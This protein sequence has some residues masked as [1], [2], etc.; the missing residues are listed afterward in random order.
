MTWKYRCKVFETLN[1]FTFWH[2]CLM[3]SWLF[4][5]IEVKRW[6]LIMEFTCLFIGR[7]GAVLALGTAD[8]AA[9]RPPAVQGAE[10]LL[11]QLTGSSWGGTLIRAVGTIEGQVVWSAARHLACF[12]AG[13]GALV[14][15]SLLPS[16]PLWRASRPVW[17][18]QTT[19]LLLST[20]KQMW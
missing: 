14:W 7:W 11:S 12:R 17:M 3:M 5:N 8:S 18:Q 1:I 13:A 2:N 16:W 6:S 15:W 20:N 19:G 10:E 9:N 4:F